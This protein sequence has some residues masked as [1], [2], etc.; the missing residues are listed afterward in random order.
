MFKAIGSITTAAIGA[1]YYFYNRESSTPT[2]HMDTI[3]S[4]ISHYEIKEALHQD[5]AYI[6]TGPDSECRSPFVQTQHEI[7]Q[8]LGNLH[9]N[10]KS[11]ATIVIHT[12]CPATPL[13]DGTAH[14]S[15]IH[16]Q[17]AQDEK[18]VRSV[19]LRTEGF[20]KLLTNGVT[21]H[22]IYS[23]GQG[24]EPRPDVP[25]TRS[26][27]ALDAY[28]INLLEHSNLHD[29]ELEEKLP[30]DLSGA[31]FWSCDA[32]DENNCVIGFIKATQANTE[33]KNWK[34][35][36]TK[37]KPTK[38]PDEALE[39]LKKHQELIERRGIKLPKFEK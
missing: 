3:L 28:K 33:C 19:D 31:T 14:A 18:S 16:P 5:G 10:G 39:E 9:M 23:H 12:D 6:K 35:A 27:S 2:N 24:V 22:S 17:I 1:A 8:V 7:E 30:P 26:A 21:V 34:I 36:L 15:N 25:Q 4:K 13:C 38:L 32:Q 37:T 11:K 29:H 20:K